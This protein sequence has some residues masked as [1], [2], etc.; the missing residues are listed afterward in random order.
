[1]SDIQDFLKE[2]LK[3]KFNQNGLVLSEKEREENLHKWLGNSQMRDVVY[4][5]S[6][7]D[8]EEFDVTK[9]SHLNYIGR[10]IYT[11]TS[12]KDV[13]ANYAHEKGGDLVNRISD[14]EERAEIN[15]E[16]Y[17]GDP[18]DEYSYIYKMLSSQNPPI[19]KEEYLKLKDDDKFSFVSKYMILKE[20]GNTE[21]QFSPVV[22]PVY[23]K[24]ENLFDANELFYFE[25]IDGI[26]DFAQ[27]I[28]DD[29]KVSEYLNK[30]NID[31]E[32]IR[33]LI[34]NV[35]NKY[36]S[37]IYTM[38]DVMVMDSNFNLS[39]FQEIEDFGDKK[40]TEL[41]GYACTDFINRNDGEYIANPPPTG[42]YTDIFHAIQDIT[43]S[44]GIELEDLYSEI[45]E[46]LYNHID[47]LDYQ[48]FKSIFDNVSFADHISGY[49]EELHGETHRA[50][51]QDIMRQALQKIG[52]DSFK[53]DAGLSFKGMKEVYSGESIHYIVFDK[54][55]IKS[56]IGNNGLYDKNDPRIAYKLE[57]FKIEQNAFNINYLSGAAENIANQFI[58]KFPVI[59]DKI[60]LFKTEKDLPHKIKKEFDKS[61]GMSSAFFDEDTKETSIF[62][63]NIKDE[64]HLEK[65]MAHEIIG[66]L[67]VK[68]V[69]GNQYNRYLESAYNY[70]DKNGL[71]DDLKVKYSEVYKT[72]N[73]DEFRRSVAEE[74]IAE[75]VENYGIHKI[76][77]YKTI[78]GKVKSVIRESF[79]SLNLEVTQNDVNYL[80]SNSYKKLQEK[81]NVKNTNFVKKIFKI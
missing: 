61:N 47:G 81:E 53:M 23:I 34:V 74:K 42:V 15:I 70:Y 65:V 80:I 30:N 71:I 22:Y 25:D 77:F 69:L 6:M 64:K 8:I 14:I 78:V 63:F 56:A 17:E 36:L 44:A 38:D 24:A 33:E 12:I 1:M 32:E 48:G 57:N 60:N 18:D 21:D 59:K 7:S 43:Y 73:S 20:F 11:S 46:D 13:N 72:K 79:P 45:K 28:L 55:Q 51:F 68:T 2:K 27:E 41:L 10:G 31:E 16:Y 3:D 40:L 39:S 52:Y 62:L 50:T 4:H 58:Q 5:A 54:S 67:G 66:H 37:A 76:P 49:H 9:S 29:T 35:T 19:E 26:N 75:T